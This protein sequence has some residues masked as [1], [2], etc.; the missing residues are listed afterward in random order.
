VRNF[1]SSVVSIAGLAYTI[2][3]SLTHSPSL[4]DA[5]GIKALA[6]WNKELSNVTGQ[7]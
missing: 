3:H 6:L 5:P 4:I 7:Q 1:V 2:T